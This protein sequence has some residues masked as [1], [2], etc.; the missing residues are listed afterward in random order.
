MVWLNFAA[1]VHELHLTWV[2]NL[3]RLVEVVEEAHF[4][5]LISINHCLN[6]TACLCIG[7]DHMQTFMSIIYPSFHGFFQSRIKSCLK[8]VSRT[9]QW[10]QCSSVA[11]PITES[12]SNRT[13]QGCARTVDLQKCTWKTASVAWYNCV[14]MN[15][16]LKAT[17]TTIELSF[18]IIRKAL[19]C[20]SAMCKVL[21]YKT[22]IL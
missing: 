3:V 17:F 11:F 14:N 1:T 22:A 19:A 10:G 4:G 8:L 16:N 2:N 18:G 7:V 21:V 13:P 12:D 9:W 20:I 15:Q 5:P 6:A